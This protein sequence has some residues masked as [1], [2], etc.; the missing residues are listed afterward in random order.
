[1]QKYWYQHRLS[2][3]KNENIGIGPIKPYQLSSN[4]YL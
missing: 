1:M 3:L 2:A 4:Y